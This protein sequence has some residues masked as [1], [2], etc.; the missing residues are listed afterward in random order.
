MV[1]THDLA[2]DLFGVLV[3][4]LFVALNGSPDGSQKGKLVTVARIHCQ[5]K[6]AD[7]EFQKFCELNTGKRFNAEFRFDSEYIG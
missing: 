5:R 4:A 1:A 6:N 2:G 7:A 3:I